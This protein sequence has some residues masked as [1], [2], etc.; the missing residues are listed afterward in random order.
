MSGG[1]QR[2][3]NAEQVR[4]RLPAVVHQSDT[5][6]PCIPCTTFGLVSMTGRATDVVTKTLLKSVRINEVTAAVNR[7][8]GGFKPNR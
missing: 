4:S 3:A 7:L 1:Y 5:S 6:I 8:S 2:P